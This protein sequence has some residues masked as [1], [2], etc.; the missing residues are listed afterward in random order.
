MVAI[1]FVNAGGGAF[2]TGGLLARGL[3]RARHA[4]ED[5][6][7]ALDEAFRKNE[8]RTAELRAAQQQLVRAAHASGMAEIAV[9]VLHNV[10]N[11]LTS[12]HVTAEELQ[13]LAQTPA[14]GGLIRANDL[15]STHEGDLPAFFSS[16]PRAAH[17]PS[18]YRKLTNALAADLQRA[19]DESRQLLEKTRLIRNTLRALQDFAANRSDGLLREKFEAAEVIDEV[20]EIQ[21]ANLDRH[22]IVFRRDL[23]EE[24]P[25]LVG[26]RRTVFH[27]IVHLVKN[28]IEAMRSSAEGSRVLTI[29]VRA[30]GPDQIEFRVSDTGEGIPPENLDRIFAFGFSTRP[31][32]NGLGLHS[33]ANDVRQLG[34]RIRVESQGRGAGACFSLLLP[35]LMDQGPPP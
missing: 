21:K 9:G 28:A 6:H 34:G 25:S 12:V 29:A 10:G 17:L 26:D 20:I 27:M 16:D 19:Q 2:L 7:L 18:Y 1:A 14:L 8:E 32:G 33:C 3:I 24:V 13:R 22:R 4:E 11:V 23:G 15:L 31:D 35:I 30:V 5:R